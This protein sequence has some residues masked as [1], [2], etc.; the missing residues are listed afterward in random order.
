ME[1]ELPTIS[2]FTTC[3]KWGSC[4]SIFCFMSMF[5]GSLFVLLS[6]FFRPLH[7]LFF[8][9]V[10]ILITPLVC[11]NSSYY[12]ISCFISCHINRYV[13]RCGF[14]VYFCPVHCIYILLSEETVK[15]TSSICFYWYCD[16]F[17]HCYHVVF[18]YLFFWALCYLF[19][20]DLQNLITPLVS[21]ILLVDRSRF[22][23][24]SPQDHLGIVSKCEF[25]I[26]W[27]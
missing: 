24:I 23:N 18:R 27:S 9:D 1:Q 16:H 4:Y 15:L 21:S 7:C 22:C 12:I 13:Y 14:R 3:F 5:C 10:R 20:F 19:F 8:F 2:E 26:K 25:F 17:D 11:S 6:F